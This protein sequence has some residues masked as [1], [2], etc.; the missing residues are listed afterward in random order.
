MTKITSAATP[1]QQGNADALR[2]IRGT[3]LAQD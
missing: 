1:D 3:G 2:S